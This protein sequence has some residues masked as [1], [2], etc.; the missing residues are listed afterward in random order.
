MASHADELK[1]AL[2]LDRDGNWDGAHRI[3]QNT[4]STDSYR[5]HAYLHRKQGDLGNSNYWYHRAGEK[6]PEHD[7]AQEWEELY[8]DITSD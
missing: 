5:I 1:K 3:V 4:E 7:L 8:E 2:E 6:V